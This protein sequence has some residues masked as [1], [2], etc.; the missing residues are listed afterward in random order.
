MG[1]LMEVVVTGIRP[2]QNILFII[3]ALFV[4]LHVMVLLIMEEL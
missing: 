1:C 2:G 4:G 3:P